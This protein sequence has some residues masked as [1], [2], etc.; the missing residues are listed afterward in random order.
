ML[1]ISVKSKLLL[2]AILLSASM[3]CATPTRGNEVKSDV[4]E[5]I[6]AAVNRPIREDGVKITLEAVYI[7]DLYHGGGLFDDSCP[8][9]SV[10]L[11]Y[12][13]DLIKDS[14]FH[15]LEKLADEN[16]YAG[17]FTVRLKIYGTLKTEKGKFRIYAI[18]LLEVEK[19]FVDHKNTSAEHKFDHRKVQGG[20]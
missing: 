1:I 14:M 19:A 6:C 18:R 15:R 16:E 3:G 20:I 8:G 10:Q 9:V 5:T 2:L 4:A 13:V 7:T 12:G 17:L 11:R